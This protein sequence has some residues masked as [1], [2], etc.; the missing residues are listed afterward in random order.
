MLVTKNVTRLYLCALKLD[1]FRF[2]YRHLVLITGIW[3]SLTAC[4][5]RQETAQQSAD[6]TAATTAAPTSAKVAIPGRLANLGITADSHWRGVNLGDDFATV[7]AKETGKRFEA[8]DRHV[9]YTVELKN[10]E[11]ADVLYYQAN[12]KVS[13][14]ETDIYANSRQSADTHQNE[15]GAYFNARYGAAKPGAD[16]LTWN[17]PSGERVT[18]KDV[19][20][21]KDFGLKVKITPVD[22]AATASAR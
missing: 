1:R 12:Q 9:G 18:L 10:L 4:N 17:G 6:S 5:T 7:K 21:G 19:S 13:A 14:I 8:D 3:V 22:G 2:M 15:L 20:K 16:G 11:T